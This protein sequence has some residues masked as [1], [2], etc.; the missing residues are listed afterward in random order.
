MLAVERSWRSTLVASRYLRACVQ[1]WPVVVVCGFRGRWS[2]FGVAVCFA[3]LVVGWS[4]S[5]LGRLLS[6]WG[7]WDCVS[8]W[9]S[10]DLTLGRRG[11]EADVGCRWAVCRGCGGVAGVV[12]VS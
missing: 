6:F 5:F 1:S 7:G 12:V 4:W 10:C 11:G 9:A 3:R 2:S 8:R